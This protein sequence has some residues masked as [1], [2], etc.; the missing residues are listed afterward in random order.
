MLRIES[1]REHYNRRKKGMLEGW[2][3][4]MQQKKKPKGLGWILYV[5]A[6]KLYLF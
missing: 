4:K 2:N 5:A 3:R 1:T 6:T